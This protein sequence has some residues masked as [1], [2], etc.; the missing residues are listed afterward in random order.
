VVLA[1]QFAMESSMIQA[2][3]VEAME[4]SELANRYRVSGVPHTVLNDGKG[5]LIGAVPETNLLAEIQRLI[6]E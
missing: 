6:Q 4:F 5:N 2:E 3:A 1:H